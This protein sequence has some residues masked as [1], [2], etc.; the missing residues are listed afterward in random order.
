MH[1]DRQEVREA[2]AGRGG[3]RGQRQV[4]VARSSNA[5]R[6]TGGEA[7]L[8]RWPGWWLPAAGPDPGRA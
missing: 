1:M 5:H 4:R 3:G 2:A 8:R 7:V 6:C